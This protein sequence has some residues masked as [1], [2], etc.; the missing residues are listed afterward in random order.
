MGEQEG[1]AAIPAASRSDSAVARCAG[2]VEVV[3]RSLRLR[4][5]DLYLWCAGDGQVGI[6]NVVRGTRVGAVQGEHSLGLVGCYR[7]GGSTALLPSAGIVFHPYLIRGSPDY[8]RACVLRVVYDRCTRC[9]AR[10]GFAAEYSC[11]GRSTVSA[12]LFSLRFVVGTAC[13][14]ERQGQEYACLK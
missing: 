13:Y 12:L 11:F 8:V 2:M 10:I 6:D 1:I 3:G 7:E 5:L 4:S 14:D 9:G